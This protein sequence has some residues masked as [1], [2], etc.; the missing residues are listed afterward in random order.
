MRAQTTPVLLSDT[1]FDHE[2]GTHKE[3][4][5]L[6]YGYMHVEDQDERAKAAHLCALR[7]AGVT[8]DCTY[9]DVG[10]AGRTHE[11]TGMVQMLR[12]GDV[13]VIPTL[14]L[15][16]ATYEEIIAQWQML[17]RIKQ[18]NLVVLDIPLL[19]MRARKIEPMRQYIADLAMQLMAY[20]ATRER[21]AVRQR[22]HEGILAA[23][24]RGVRFGRPPKPIP[25][26]FESLLAQ[27][28]AREISSRQAAKQLG[29]AQETFLRWSR[30]HT[31][32]VEA[33]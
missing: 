21:E 1:E 8:E 12:K 24:E 25:P 6:L 32:Q 4:C 18:I 17:T 11:Y 9:I 33:Y 3:P 20:A 29:V 16:G 26:Q 2:V 30:K 23:K 14:G 31:S 5:G 22:Q 28:R 19:D 13:L 27:W 15:L 7:T 10:P